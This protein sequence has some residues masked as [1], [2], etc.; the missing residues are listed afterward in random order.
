MRY[1]STRGDVYVS[2][3]DV[4]LSGLSPDGGLYVPEYIPKIDE[5]VINSW[6][7]LSFQALAFE[8]MRY[9]IE[10][11]EIPDLDL[12]DI[13]RRAFRNFQGIDV[14]PISK[15]GDEYLLELFHGPT[16]SF[17]DIALQVLGCFFEYF[18]KKLNTDITIVGATSGDTGSAAISALKGKE[19]INCV[20]LYPHGRISKIQQLQMTT[21]TDSNIQC[22]AIPG[23]FDD[24]Q[25]LV[26]EL[27]TVGT[28]KQDMNLG[29]INSINWARI[30][31]QMIYYWYAGFRILDLENSKT[32]VE[33]VDFCVPTGNF[34]NILA[35]YYCRR[36]GGPVGTLTI[37]SNSNNLLTRCWLSGSYEIETVVSTLAPA[38]D[39]QVASNFERYI[40]E[41]ARYCGYEDPSKTVSELFKNL[42][43][44][45][46]FHLPKDIFECFKKDFYAFD[47]SDK[48]IKDT[49]KRVYKMYHTLID[50]HTA[51]GVICSNK[52][53]IQEN[54]R[55]CVATAHFGKFHETV[56]SVLGVHITTP[57]IP[58][59]LSNLYD[60][61]EKS[62][63][64]KKNINALVNVMKNN[65]NNNNYIYIYSILAII[66]IFLIKN[67]L[68]K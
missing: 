59:E 37:C 32:N 12:K 39:I 35:G 16:Y 53:P 10:K 54:A 5:F 58:K 18:V 17:K 44:K 41:A 4:V 33:L 34:G 29:A 13:I 26:K 11:S 62:K 63:K 24:C 52:V 1:I 51:V 2:F 38:M 25:Q 7:K 45:K 57:E 48:D 21:V 28:Y 31:C 3:I 60:L 27:F 46:R 49:I 22:L 42:K 6:K 56:S 23:S 36:M 8:I 15:L 20:I 9:F 66:T 65:N 61:P 30:M 40:F 68:K 47:A 19:G 67:M 55:C 14:T 50:P 43:I 64:I